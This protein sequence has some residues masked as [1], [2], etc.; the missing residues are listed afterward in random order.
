MYKNAAIIGITAL[1]GLGGSAYAQ[2]GPAAG[3]ATGAI[4]G[5]I[6][7]GPVGAIVGGA[8]GAMI[9]GIADADRTQFR[10]YVQERRIQPYRWDGQVVVGATLPSRG[11]EYYEVPDRFNVQDYRYTVV[12][13][14]TVIV[15]P[16]NN[17]IVEIIE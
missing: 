6:V 16:R 17:R 8:A 2:G 7:G 9:G 13:G 15:D 10:T 5:A 4:G 11:V 14:K 3:A 12:N 1:L